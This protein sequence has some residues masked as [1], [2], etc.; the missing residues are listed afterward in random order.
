[1]SAPTT[2]A[3]FNFGARCITQADGFFFFNNNPLLCSMSGD[4]L[5]TSESVNVTVLSHVSRV[6]TETCNLMRT[7]QDTMSICFFSIKHV[8]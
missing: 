5:T 3:T 1:M 2:I 8:R 4:Y 6:D 7:P